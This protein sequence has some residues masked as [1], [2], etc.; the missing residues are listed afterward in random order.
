MIPTL[1]L[2]LLLAS[3]A[4]STTAHPVA[5]DAAPLVHHTR[6]EAQRFSFFPLQTPLAG[7]CDLVRGPDDALWGQGILAN[8]IF[9]IDPV[10][11]ATD[12]YTIPFT[13]PADNQTI[14]GVPDLVG[15]RGAL[16]CAI[17]GGADGKLYAANGEFSPSPR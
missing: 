15:Q 5:S 13:V 14:P 6:Q 11:G 4:A 2:S 16:S 12:E 7:P 1:R 10:T 8:I 9:R 17:R 3:L